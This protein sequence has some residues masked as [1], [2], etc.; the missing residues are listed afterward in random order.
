LFVNGS[1]EF[2]VIRRNMK[3]TRAVILDR[4]KDP[5]AG[6]V[7]LSKRPDEETAEQSHLRRFWTFVFEEWRDGTAGDTLAFMRA[8]LA[9]SYQGKPPPR[10]LVDALIAHEIEHMSQGERQDRAALARHKARWE[11]MEAA[12]AEDLSHE[13]ARAAASARLASSDAAGEPRTVRESYEIINDAGGKRA[14]LTSYRRARQ[15][16]NSKAE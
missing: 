6:L 16:R 12:L 7:L 9:C 10:G 1:E 8:L 3:A 14:S 4:V 11:A 5:E 2:A 15:Q 13:R